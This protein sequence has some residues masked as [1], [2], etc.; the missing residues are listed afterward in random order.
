MALNDV[1]ELSVPDYR[2]RQ[3]EYIKFSG[4]EYIQDTYKPYSGMSLSITFKFNAATEGYS[5]TNGDGSSNPNSANNTIGSN[6]SGKVAG[7]MFGSYRTFSSYNATDKHKVTYDRFTGKIYIDD[8]QVYDNGSGNYG[9]TAANPITWGARTN[10]SGVIGLYMQANVYAISIF[11]ESALTREYIPAQRKSDGVCGLYSHKGVFYPMSGTEITTNAAGPTIQE[12][13]NMPVKKIEDSNSDIIWGSQSAFPYRRL[14]YIIFSGSE[15]IL[16]T[17]KPT[18]NRYYYLDF[19]LSSIVNDKFIFAANGNVTSDGTMRVT[20]RTSSAG[21]AQ[22]RYGRNSS[23]NSNIVAVTTNTKYQHRLR[24]YNDYKAY[25][26]LADTSGSVLGSKY[27]STAITFT[28]SGMYPFA[29]MAYNNGGTITGNTAGIVYRY[30]YRTGDASGT[31]TSNCYPCQRKSDGVCGLYDILNNT[32]FPMGGTN[33]TS[34]AAGPL[35]DE[36]WDLTE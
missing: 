26:A 21:Y 7:W 33:I 23:S 24:I 29:I 6:G 32:F 15:Y 5:G 19:S 9:P 35:V 1:K 18:N 11:N 4:A 14:E 13:V 27:Y 17:H 10:T 2:Y 22:S 31:I 28:P 3:L 20:T 30:F 12:F 25:F 16:T 36:Y 8:T 34:A